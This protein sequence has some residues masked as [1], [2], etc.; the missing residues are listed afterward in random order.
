MVNGLDMSP[1]QASAALKD[2]G[3]SATDISMISRGKVPDDL[4]D[5]KP[6]QLSKIFSESSLT[7]R[8]KT[9]ERMMTKEERAE[10]RKARQEYLQALRES[11]AATAD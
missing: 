1:R 9:E 2:A 10:A 3:L 6:G 5:L 8:G 4:E 11:G 7:Q